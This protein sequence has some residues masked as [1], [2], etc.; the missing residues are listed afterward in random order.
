M[1]TVKVSF[2]RHVCALYHSFNYFLCF[3]VLVTPAS[4]PPEDRGRPAPTPP[5]PDIAEAIAEAV[6]AV[7]HRM[8][9]IPA[10]VIGEQVFLK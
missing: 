6:G 3:L 1:K 5:E 2:L 9:D 7:V 8:R 4:P 10:F